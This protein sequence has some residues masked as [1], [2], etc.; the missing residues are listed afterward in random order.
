MANE[1]TR[2]EMYD[3]INA[4]K[5]VFAKTYA[6]FAPHEYIMRTYCKDKE[7]FDRAG[8][9]I[10]KN[11]MRM[12]YYKSERKYLYCDGYFYWILRDENNYADAVI[13]RCKPED[14]DIVFMQRGTQARAKAKA[15]EAKRKTEQLK[16][17]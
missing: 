7:A 16:F 5:W 14:Y 12:F 8:E 11:G 17:L 1:M 10:L 13:N 3:F 6:A 4:Q 9:F 15:E 2:R